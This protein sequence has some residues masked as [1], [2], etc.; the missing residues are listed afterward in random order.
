MPRGIDYK[1]ENIKAW[2]FDQ[3]VEADEVS[4]NEFHIGF[5][6]V[7]LDEVFQR[8]RALSPLYSYQDVWNL[9]ADEDMSLI[10]ALEAIEYEYEHYDDDAENYYRD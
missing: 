5:D 10:E 7:P 6:G 4:G 1:P 9:M 8:L 2:L 3:L